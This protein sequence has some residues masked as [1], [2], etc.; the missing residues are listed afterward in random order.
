M[1][2]PLT[3]ENAR[4]FRNLDICTTHIT[5]EDSC[6]AAETYPYGCCDYRSG[7]LVWVPA[8]E[9][10]G[11][12]LPADIL[13]IRLDELLQ[14]GLSVAFCNVIRLAVRHNCQQIT[15]DHLGTEYSDMERFDW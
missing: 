14:K 13:E 12:Q 6:R 10:T 5:Y 4:I 9:E 2:K 7:F 11:E 8:N 3:S 1:S 15:I